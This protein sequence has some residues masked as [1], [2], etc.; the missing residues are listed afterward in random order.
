MGPRI[1]IQLHP[2]VG[3]T[4]WLRK[5]RFELPEVRVS[6]NWVYW[7][8]GGLL[9]VSMLGAGL[10]WLS[11]QDPAESLREVKPLDATE[12]ACPGDCDPQNRGDETEKF[13][14]KR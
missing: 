4:R 14:E 11:R 1:G 6:D 3:A 8:V 5:V 7:L 9:A 10:L 2:F 13:F 12:Q